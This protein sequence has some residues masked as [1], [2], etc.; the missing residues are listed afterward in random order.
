MKNLIY[1]IINILD[2]S[3]QFRNLKVIKKELPY[4]I[5]LFIDVGAHRGESLEFFNKHF[6]IKKKYYLS[7]T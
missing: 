2:H 3:I 7:Q 5:N 6:K 4:K 1:K